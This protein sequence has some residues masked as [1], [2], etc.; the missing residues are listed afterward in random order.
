MSDLRVMA[1]RI[2]LIAIRLHN[3]ERCFDV[4]L[5]PEHQQECRRLAEQLESIEREL[6]D[7]EIAQRHAKNKRCKKAFDPL[8]WLATNPINPQPSTREVQHA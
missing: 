4:G 6:I 8:R 3:A 5:K 1:N 7:M 2:K